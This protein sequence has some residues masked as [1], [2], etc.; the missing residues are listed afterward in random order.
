MVLLALP[1]HG[2]SVSFDDNF[3]NEDDLV[4]S[5]FIIVIFN[6]TSLGDTG[7]YIDINF[8]RYYEDCN[9]NPNTIIGVVYVFRD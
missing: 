9:R 1:S 6:L 2:T 5:G 3:V 4:H 7:A 8:K